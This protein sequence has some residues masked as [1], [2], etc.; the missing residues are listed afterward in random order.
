MSRT[1]LIIHTVQEVANDVQT[2]KTSVDELQQSQGVQLH[3]LSILLKTLNGPVCETC[4]RGNPHYDKPKF[5]ITRTN[6]DSNRGNHDRAF[7][8]NEYKA[9]PYQPHINQSPRYHISSTA[10]S[11]PASYNA[12]PL[13]ARMIEEG[14][15]TVL[16]SKVSTSTKRSHPESPPQSVKKQD[17]RSKSRSL[18]RSVPRRSVKRT[19][20]EGSEDDLSE[21]A[22]K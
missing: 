19:D 17:K 12:N 7:R 8:P 18:S 3:K 13:V 21:A 5:N 16:P 2:L 10:S 6:N 15:W 20:E 9:R 11:T 14:K 4:N 1:D 22:R